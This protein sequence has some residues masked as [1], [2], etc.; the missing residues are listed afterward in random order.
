MFCSND[1]QV[2]FQCACGILIFF[3]LNKNEMF[4]MSNTFKVCFVT[5]D[6]TPSV[7][8]IGG[9]IRVI[10]PYKHDDIA[11]YETS[12]QTALLK[13]DDSRL[14]AENV[15]AG[16]YNIV[17]TIRGKTHEIT[18]HVPHIK[19]PFVSGYEITNATSDFARDGLVRANVEHMP[20]DCRYWWTSG[21]ITHEPILKDVSPG[22]YIICPI[23]SSTRPIYHLHHAAAAVVHVGRYPFYRE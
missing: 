13:L 21:V 12:G 4:C 1:T 11:W 18:A 16:T 23:D 15:Q 6:I 19:L 5:I 9:S 22:T 14:V 10:I 2:I 3:R 20:R 17:I 7:S 8:N